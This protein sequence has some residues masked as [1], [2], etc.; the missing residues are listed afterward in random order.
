MSDKQNIASRRF[1]SLKKAKEKYQRNK[2]MIG[3]PN[4]SYGPLKDEIVPDELP[5][6]YIP[7]PFRDT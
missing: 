4:R 1:N 3:S 5:P 7:K 6:Q 2:G